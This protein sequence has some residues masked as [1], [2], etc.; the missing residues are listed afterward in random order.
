[1][2]IVLVAMGVSGAGK[3]TLGKL[4]A[5]RLGWPFQEG[6]D[7]HP[8]A[9][10][11]KMKAGHPLDDADRAPWLAAIG[12]WIDSQIAS[13]RQRRHHLLSAETRLSRRTGW[14]PAAGA[15]RLPANRRGNHRRAAEASRGPL[16]APQPARQPVRRPAA[17]HRRRAGDHRRWQAAGSG[18]GRERGGAAAGRL[19]GPDALPK[20]LDHP[21]IRAADIR[22]L[23]GAMVAGE[24]VAD[25]RT[26]SRT[27]P[28]RGFPGMTIPF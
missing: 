28:L 27:S 3:S 25:V 16:H 1:M 10:I 18:A 8:A 5:E 9:N 4:L 26:R 19:T 12:R 14:R 17:A 24:G 23:L 20:R 13:G 21:G 22:D 7:L 6:D 2:T 15:L 11:A